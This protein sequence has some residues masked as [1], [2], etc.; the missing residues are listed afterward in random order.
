MNK[1]K[2]ALSGIIKNNPTFVLVLGMCPTLGTTTSAENG[3][4]MGLATAAVLILSN[5]VISLIKN[6]IPDK[7]RI[8]AFIVVIASFVTI[9]Q[10]LMQAFATDLYE[11][12]GVFIP[13]I[14]VN[15]IILG[16]AEAFASKNSPIDSMLDGVGVGLG[17]TLSLTV[18]GAV[19]EILGNGSIFGLPLHLTY[20]D[21]ASGETMSYMPLIFVLAPGA[22]LV[23]GYLMILFNKIAK[24]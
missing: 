24:K 9:I 5:L 6:L 19:R 14:V 16:R 23:L 2:I 8:P 12:L 11:S 1:L 7:V 10:M 13:L 22:F 4:G 3:M 15:C 21:A 18:I 17:F 20:V